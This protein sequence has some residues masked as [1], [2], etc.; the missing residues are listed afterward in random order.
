MGKTVGGQMADDMQMYDAND[1]LKR[2]GKR[3]FDDLPE[4]LSDIDDGS[5][6][7]HSAYNSKNLGKKGV[8]GRSDA[9][10]S[11]TQAT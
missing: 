6:H 7:N 10:S 9:H 8:D 1:I 11:H 3:N 2:G 5:L 4:G